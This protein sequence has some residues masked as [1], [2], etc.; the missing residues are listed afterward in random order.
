[1]SY[2]P[3]T[4]TVVIFGG[5]DG[6]TAYDDTWSWD[7][8]QWSQLHP[9]ISP[10]PLTGAIMAYEP[11][12]RRLVLTGGFSS[13]PPGSMSAATWTWDGA[14][15]ASEPK[16]GLPPAGATPGSASGG[17][18]LATDDATGQL[19]LVSSPGGS[20]Q[21][22]ETWD[23]S[24][25][26][27]VRLHPATSPPSAGRG[28][29]AYDPSTRRTVLDT[30]PTGDCPGPAASGGVSTVA[31]SWDGSDWSLAGTMSG[32]TAQSSPKMVLSGELVSSPRHPLLV[33][34]QG[35][36]VWGSGGWEQV[37]QAP[38]EL[39]SLASVGG[40]TRDG[41][42]VAYDA[43]RHQVV[44]FGGEYLDATGI[45]YLSD[46][47]TWDGA[48][49]LRE[50]GSVTTPPPSPAPTPAPVPTPCTAPV[51]DLANVVGNL[52][53]HS[54]TTGWAQ[55]LADG[56]PLHTTTGADQ[57]T[58]AAPPLAPREKVAAA[59]FLDANTAWVVYASQLCVGDEVTSAVMVSWS[60]TDGG[61]T[62]RQGGSFETAGSG[63]GTLDFVDREHGWYS[64]LEGVAMGSSAMALYRTVD[65]GN[66]WSEVARTDAQEPLA[67]GSAG[68]IPFVDLKEGAV[69]VT[70]ATG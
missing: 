18:S 6:T 62:W 70:P 51:P 5:D 49:T 19:I 17:A 64:D 28:L 22:A 34:W 29:L 33:V 20:C 15:W 16:G 46:T 31:W 43:D 55:E 32:D 25:A 24:G 30:V 61:V 13:W 38:G 45:D 10:P 63:T 50:R 69:F 60:T 44:L 66:H 7:G 11:K 53:M 54:P 27:W 67:G 40:A 42:A 57:W 56:T 41:P 9:A 37:G 58:V 39:G 26:S 36:Y 3:A 12:S 4:H 1:M 23:W 52:R 35:T 65:G 14:S 59:A 47:W 21:P 48:W 68:S 8:S 2:D